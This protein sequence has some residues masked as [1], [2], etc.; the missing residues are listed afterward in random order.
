MIYW[1]GG[2]DIDFPSGARPVVNSASGRFRPT[3]SRHAIK[4]EFSY[5]KLF[6]IIKKGWLHFYG[7]MLSGYTGGRCLVGVVDSSSSD[8]LWFGLGSSA[9]PYI[10]KRSEGTYT[11]LATR[12]SSAVGYRSFDLFFDYSESGLVQMYISGE[13]DP[14]LSFSGDNL[15][16][17]VEGFTRVCINTQTSPSYGEVSE[18]IVS[19]TDTR[20]M[21]LRTLSPNA[22]GDVNQF[23]GGYAD[24][25]DET[26]NDLDFMVATDPNL[27]GSVNLTAVGSLPGVP[28]A[29]KLVS[30]SSTSDDAL[31]LRMGFTSNSGIYLADPLELTGN[32]TTYEEILHFNPLTSKVFTAAELDDIQLTFKTVSR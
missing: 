5:S 16:S 15:V 27:V 7:G 22:A 19:D 31:D 12:T 24:I 10:Y 6:P 21:S 25:D 14:I 3:Y 13:A 18:I 29:I 32:F 8:G 11:T 20:A 1:C 26:I 17:G 4:G 23:T 28:K 2:E 30:R 9:L